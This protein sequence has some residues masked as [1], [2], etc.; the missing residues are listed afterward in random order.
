MKFQLTFLFI[1][2]FQLLLFS[3]EKKGKENL[4]DIIDISQIQIRTMKQ[5]ADLD[6]IKRKQIISDSVYRPYSEFWN[7]YV[8]GENSTIKWMNNAIP[9]LP[10]FLKR[11]NDVQASLLKSQLNEINRKMYRF[12]GHK[13]T[14]KWYIAYGPAWTDLGGL[15]KMAMLID[16]SH[17]SNSTNERVVKMFPH[18]LTHQIMTLSNPSEDNT[19]LSVI[20]GEGF[21]VYINQKFWKDKYTLAEN[22]GYSEKELKTCE[23]EWSFINDYFLANQSST[24]QSVIDSFRNRS[25]KLKP[26]LPGAIGYYIGY[27]ITE[28]YVKLYGKNAWKDIFV[29]S[30]K[31]IISLIKKRN[32]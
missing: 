5:C 27:R 21:A 28:Q 2:F 3:Q 16:L 9:H 22:L 20:L 13:A 30:P 24:N 18:E 7:G 8:G 1:L 23:E 10:D 29:K 32:K 26:E 14:G 11:N 12:T 15:G 19:A 4:L 6:S 25:V 17:E 31:E